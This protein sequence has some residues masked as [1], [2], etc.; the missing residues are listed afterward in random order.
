MQAVFIGNAAWQRAPGV[1]ENCFL[2]FV[3]GGLCG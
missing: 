3:F 2:F 1:A